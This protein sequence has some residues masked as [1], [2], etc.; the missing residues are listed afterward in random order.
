MCKC[1]PEVKTPFCGKP[2]CEWP[3][4]VPQASN[5]VSILREL[6]ACKDLHD[7]IEAA[8]KLPENYWT[9]PAELQE[10]REDYARRKPE[11][12]LAAREALRS[13]AETAARHTDHS[14]PC[15]T[16][17]SYDLPERSA[18]KAAVVHKSNCDSR[19][20]STNGG[21]FACSCGAEKAP[22]QPEG[23]AFGCNGCD[24]TVTVAF[25]DA[26][27]TQI[28]IALLDG[29]TI[30]CRG[31][32]CPKCSAQKTTERPTDGEPV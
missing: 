29:W 13:A 15:P 25:T 21:G 10:K 12:W 7:E 31:T 23:M 28:S 26:T 19:L 14:I 2:G 30:S 27:K 32:L 3:P 22:S 17:G 8:M 20:D 4:Q 11:A 9:I 6:V 5:L 1:T 16:C 18:E 24:A